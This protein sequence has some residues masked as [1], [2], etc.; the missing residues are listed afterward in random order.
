[1]PSNSSMGTMVT[2]APDQNGEL[3]SFWKVTETLCLRSFSI[4]SLST[5]IGPS[6]SFLVLAPLF[7]SLTQK[8]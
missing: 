6:A 2:S 3:S 4:R 5:F 7:G 8:M 1:M